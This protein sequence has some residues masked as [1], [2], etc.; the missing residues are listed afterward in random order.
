MKYIS[1]ILLGLFLSFPLYADN[2]L[3]GMRLTRENGLPDKN[4]RYICQSENGELILMMLYDAYAYDGY[5]FRKLP[6]STYNRLREESLAHHSLTNDVS[7]DNRGNEVSIEGN[8]IRYKDSMT[9]ET[10]L[11]NIFDARWGKLTKNLKCRVVTDSEGYIWIALNG[12]GLFIYNREKHQL[13]HYT[14]DDGTRLIDTNALVYMTIDRDDRVWIAQD[15]Y[16]LLCIRRM[17]HNYQTVRPLQPWQD[18]RQGEIRMM[19]RLGDGTIIM[20][21]N[22]GSVMRA[23]GNL[24]NITLQQ[25]SDENYLAAALDT[26]GRLWLGSRINGVQVEG[27]TIGTGR[28]DCIICDHQGRM[29]T[30]GLNRGVSTSGMEFFANH[31]NL[32]PHMML[33]DSYGDIWLG[34]E[35]GLFVFKPEE[36]LKDSTAYTKVMDCG[37][38]SL[39][40]DSR[41]TLW[42]GT[43]HHGLFYTDAKRQ[44]TYRFEHIDT[45][46]GLT[47]NSVQSIA[48]DNDGIVCI[49]TMDG[50]NFYNP[51][52]KQLST[53]Y[54]SNPLQN[55]FE[56]NSIAQLDDGRL[57]LGTLDGILVTS[58]SDATTEEA[59]SPVELTNLL[60]NGVAMFD[61]REMP[62]IFSHNHNSL[63]FHFSC[64]NFGQQ[65]DFTYWLEGYDNEWSEPSQ[66][67]FASYKNLPPGHY[68]LHV[69]GRLPGSGWG[70]ELLVPITI[71]PPLWATW[72][73]Y[74]AYLLF[75][76]L[77]TC[78]IL[79]QLKKTNALRQR[80]AIEKQLTEY[81]L[82]FFTNISHEFRTPLTLI[83]ASM[84]K[85]HSLTDVPASA[86]P[87]LNSMQRNVDRMLRLINQLLEFRRMQNNKLSLALESTE[88]VGFVHNICLSFHDTAEQKRIALS[89]LPSMKSYQIY[90]DQ[91][92]VDKAVYNL[93]SNAFKYTHKGGSVTVKLKTENDHLNISVADT[94]VGVP[95]S[96][97]QTIFDRYAHGKMGRDSLGIGLDLTAELIRTHHG[98]IRCEANLPQGSIFT[99]TLPTNK[100]VYEEKDFICEDA[101]HGNERSDV[102]RGFEES[103]KEMQMSPMNDR[104]VMVV[105]DDA[106]IASYLRQELGRYFEVETACDGEEAMRLIEGQHFDLIVTDA[107]MPRM[108]GYELLKRIKN[109]GAT[110]HLPV[111]MLT[112]L[113]S[114]EQQLRGLDAGADAYITKPFSTA[115]LLLQCRNLIQRG[116]RMK[117]A[118]ERLSPAC[119]QQDAGRRQTA[120]VVI[121]ERDSRLMSLLAIWVD[122]HLAAPDLSVDR[123]AADMGYGRTVFYSK[124]KNLTGLTP[125]EYIKERRL[126]KAKE[127]LADDHVTVAEVAYQIGMGT[128]QYLSS[129]FKKRYGL[130]PSQ[131]QKGQ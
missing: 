40:I 49:G 2:E 37:V 70:G 23:D 103:V 9:G 81:K 14:K 126:E 63:T 120:A 89:F 57:A 87:A 38:R 129:C 92:F 72:Y 71:R 75:A 44:Q 20:A 107:V 36:L 116:D 12:F 100:D 105:E 118:L 11:L 110:R 31:P 90:V 15:H 111:V 119:G 19:R 109:G 55:F 66:W 8:N 7:F 27:Q 102:A 32:N 74:V 125:N 17:P 58:P 122:S 29:W 130:T 124:L 24:H 1:A 97:R 65:T 121:D 67:N 6:D 35:Q 21:D 99:I 94:G 98:T 73:A 45:G 86:R 48:A 84:D 46:D 117:D 82:K 10:I 83:N 54:V 80:V 93:L 131:F 127:L 61:E 91:G 85:L 34:T 59:K 114:Q 43:V 69:K 77:I 76:I 64:F 41:Q 106:A 108:N 123:F 52:T 13:K 30:C 62:L 50:C 95:E 42:I 26:L 33:V 88:I 101:P 79:R 18:E 53:L 5:Q 3:V 56:E 112:A 22:A 4:I 25:A 96:Q 104:K 28:T 78:L 115:L 68:T 51:Q 128:P 39:F 16:G 113:D 47:N 60:V